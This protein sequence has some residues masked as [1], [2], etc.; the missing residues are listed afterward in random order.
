MS[1]V[2]RKPIKPISIKITTQAS[3]YGPSPPEEIKA[4]HAS[5]SSEK[6]DE[7]VGGVT[8]EEEL[9]KSDDTKKEDPKVDASCY[10]YEGEVCIYTDPQSK[11]QYTWD[12]QTNDWKTR[13]CVQMG[14]VGGRLALRRE[15]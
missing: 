5:P 8:E 7:L 11:V 6:K 3:E 2:T 1:K 4:N 12:T 10:S 13:E 14:R 9:N 15:G